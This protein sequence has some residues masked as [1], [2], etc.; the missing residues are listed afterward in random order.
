MIVQSSGGPGGTGS[1]AGQVLP[2][3]LKG[4]AGFVIPVIFRAAVPIFL[5]CT[6]RLEFEPT[7]VVGKTRIFG[8]TLIS[9]VIT[10]VPLRL[11]VTGVAARAGVMVM[12]D[13]TLPVIVG[14]NR[15]V[16]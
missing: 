11:T 12:L 10:P 2:V 3:I 14:A 7:S 16:I 6:G 8:N 5:T 4:D 15:T 9:G 1:V 13:E